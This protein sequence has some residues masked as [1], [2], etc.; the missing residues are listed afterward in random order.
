MPPPLPRVSAGF[1][2][3][4]DQEDAPGAAPRRAVQVELFLDLVCPFSSTMWQAVRTMQRKGLP[5]VV[6]NVSFIVHQVPQPWHPQGAWVHEAA[7]AVRATTP[8]AYPQFLDEVYAAYDGGAF[9]DDSTWN[10]TR[11]EVYSELLTLA[12]AA[13]ANRDA[14]AALLQRTEGNHGTFVA[15]DL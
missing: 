9:K 1:N 3:C 15:Q 14:A 12:V 4:Q 7:L 10:K 2:L 5:H 8:A 6:S 13:G 11:P